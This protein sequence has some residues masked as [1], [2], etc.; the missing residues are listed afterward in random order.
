MV[1]FLGVE[2]ML[3]VPMSILGA[4]FCRGA[5]L[6]DTEGFNLTCEFLIFLLGYMQI[7]NAIVILNVIAIW[8]CYVF[9]AV[10]MLLLTMRIIS[11][12]SDPKVS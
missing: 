10:T 9:S 2:P 12:N 4:R 6:Q 5:N 3:K 7:L 1:G 8:C 11:W